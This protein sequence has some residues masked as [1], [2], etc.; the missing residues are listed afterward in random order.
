MVLVLRTGETIPVARAPKRVIA[1]RILDEMMK[2]RL[3]LHAAQ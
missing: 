1:R 3:A 2:L